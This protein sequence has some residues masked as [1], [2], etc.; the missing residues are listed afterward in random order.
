MSGRNGTM[1][2][3]FTGFTGFTG[4]TPGIGTILPDNSPQFKVYGLI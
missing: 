2:E 1:F 3:G 4:L